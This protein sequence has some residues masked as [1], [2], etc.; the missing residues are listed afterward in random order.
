M[1]NEPSAAKSG[2]LLVFAAILLLV[3]AGIY[4]GP[5]WFVPKPASAPA[6]IAAT[7][8]PIPRETSTPPPAVEPVAKVAAAP[9]DATAE[10]PTPPAPS[11]NTAELTDSTRVVEPA[12]AGT[13]G[14]RL[15][16]KSRMAV[17]DMKRLFQAHPKTKPYEEQ[18][19]A[20]RQAAREEL[21]R[22]TASGDADAIRR[23]RET[24]EKEVGDEANR[25]RKEIA[26]EIQQQVLAIVEK[27]DLGVVF[28]LSGQT[29]NGAPL[30]LNA[31]GLLDLTDEV[32]KALQQ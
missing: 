14:P 27:R 32:A 5:N 12:P 9:R 29:L 3:V 10:V 16:G 19:N 25:L 7:A 15:T 23:F 8:T 4:F 6:P 24:K 22:L 13:P 31:A 28:D 1:K 26:D 18:V 30:V 2:R 11:G 20:K 21:E 17:I